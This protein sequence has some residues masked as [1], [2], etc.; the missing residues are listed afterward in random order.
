MFFG[1]WDEKR[2]LE[3]PSAD[4]IRQRRVQQARERT[5]WQE[6]PEERLVRR[7]HW[8]IDA[9]TDA[10]LDVY[11]G[12]VFTRDGLV[13]FAEDRDDLR[14]YVSDASEIVVLEP[15]SLATTWSDYLYQRGR[16]R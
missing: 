9:E 4:E 12:D 2:E 6:I 8:L 10:M 7:E 11:R 3:Q 16:A 15:S 5:R 13:A 14:F 1:S